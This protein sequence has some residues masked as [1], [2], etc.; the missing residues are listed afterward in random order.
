MKFPSM[1]PVQTLLCAVSLLAALGLHGAETCTDIRSMMQVWDT[2]EPTLAHTFTLT[3][4]VHTTLDGLFVIDDGSLLISVLNRTDPHVE[5]RPGNRVTISG[6]FGLKKIDYGNE[7]YTVA[8]KA[9][10]LSV[11]TPPSPTRCGLQ[12]LSSSRD[13][14]RLVE[15]SGTVIDYR[16]D[17]ADPDYLHLTLKDGPTIMPVSIPAADAESVEALI[18]ARVSVVGMFYRT[19]QGVRR[20]SRPFISTDLKDIRTVAPPPAPEDIPVLERKIYLTPKDI[21]S[22]GKRKI[23]GE[24]IAVWQKVNLLLRDDDNRIVRVRLSSRNRTV[25]RAGV[26]ATICG[27]PE[28]DQFNIILGTATISDISSHGPAADSPERLASPSAIIAQTPTGATTFTPAYYGKLVSLRGTVRSLPPS[29]SS[30]GRISLACDGRLVNLDSSACP[31]ASEGLEL[32]CIIEA[33]GICLFEM[34][35]YDAQTDTPHVSGLTL[36]LRGKDDVVIIARPSWLT[37]LRFLVILSAMAGV[38]VLILIWNHALRVLVERRGRE[39]ARK[40]AETLNAR[41]KT[42]ERTRLATELHDAVVQSLTGAALEIRAA[43]ASLGEADADAAPHM[44]I[45][46]KTINSSRAELRNCIWDL[47]NRA[48]EEKTVDEAIR[49]TLKPHLGDTKVQIRFNVSRRKIPDTE[50]HNIISIIRELVVNAIRHGQAQTVR[51][52]G[53]LDRGRILFSVTDDGCGFDPK[54]APGMEQ[55]HFGI[56]GVMERA[57]TLD[58]TAVISSEV[59]KGTRVSVDVALMEEAGQ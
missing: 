29:G 25:P 14:L 3:G 19:I 27:Y 15:T 2:T 55:G 48:L 53:T 10:V 59:G 26:R 47:R 12:E 21:L 45:A 23:C 31:E 43:M 8:L 40:Q 13:N 35:D 38:L 9:R 49:I 7:P 1:K 51:I 52:A 46:L 42:A 37:P 17:D 24:I 5:L 18:D 44:D 41:L 22:L 56:E 57:K 39:L 11:G 4:T 58:G 36:V 20:Y 30:E 34:N 32:G 16:P 6:N 50:L 33:A 54:G 28:T